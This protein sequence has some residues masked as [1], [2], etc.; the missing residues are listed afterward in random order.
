MSYEAHKADFLPS[1]IP[2]LRTIIRQY[3]F[4]NEA[5]AVAVCYGSSIRTDSKVSDIDMLLAEPQPLS[6]L[7]RKA[8]IDAFVRLHN[9]NGRQLDTEVPY[10]NKLFYTY[11]EIEESLT[12]SMLED[13]EGRIRIPNLSKLSSDD[14]YFNSRAMKLRLCFNAFT[15]T[16]IFIAGNRTIYNNLC[17][18]AEV[19]LA[20]L[21][22][23]LSMQEQREISG[24]AAARQLLACEGINYKD[25]LGY[26]PEDGF[27]NCCL[28]KALGLLKSTPAQEG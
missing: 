16:H 3:G 25:Y 5:S 9:D 4:T 7:K 17:K 22:E 24:I 21:V 12:H 19:S 28:E 20:A 6:G 1:F 8:F 10:D 14:T 27:F 23:R 13:E 18:K 11:D 15:S 26:H 2:D